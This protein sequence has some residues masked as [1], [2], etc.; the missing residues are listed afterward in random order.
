MTTEQIT[1]LK[2]YLA[3]GEQMPMRAAVQAAL[4]SA[5]ELENRPRTERCCECGVGVTDWV[6]A[7]H[8]NGRIC[9]PCEHNLSLT[10]ELEK[11]K[12]KRKEACGSSVPS[13][14]DDWVDEVIGLLRVTRGQRDTEEKV[15]LGYRDTAVQLRKENADLRR[16][17]ERCQWSKDLPNEQCS[18]WWWN[19][20]E[21]SAP[22]HV[23]IMYSGTSGTYFASH[24]QYGWTEAQ[25]CSDMGGWWMKIVDPD[26][27]TREQVDAAI[28]SDADAA[29]RKEVAK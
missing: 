19:G 20:D 3:S 5:E 12:A 28:A 7:E 6:E 16:D 13:N 22:I 15:A 4:N 17:R 14:G 27:P 23:H 2:A 11:V 9:R 26:P 29:N 1:E 8:R 10:D 24:G 21:D 18:W 25:D